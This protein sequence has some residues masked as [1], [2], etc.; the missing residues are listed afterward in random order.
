MAAQ[1]VFTGVADWEHVGRVTIRLVA[2]ILAGGIIGFE[3]EE[4]RKVAGLRTHMLVSLG[5]ALFVLAPLEMG[6]S[7]DAATRVMQGLVAGIGFLGAGAILKLQDIRQVKGLTTAAT[8]WVT[9]AIGMTIGLGL[10][11]P[12]L[13]GTIL[14]FAV[15]YGM[16]WVDAWIEQLRPPREGK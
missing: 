2:A 1:E 12:A 11:W 14:T 13:I 10:L 6:L 4:H 15:I 9:A 7:K 8:I 5:S 16:T 3:R